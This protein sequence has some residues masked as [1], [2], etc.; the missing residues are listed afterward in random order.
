MT[1]YKGATRM[2]AD[3]RPDEKAAQWQ[4]VR[5]KTE[6][7]WRKVKADGT[8]DSMSGKDFRDYAFAVNDAINNGFHPRQDYW[9]IVTELG[10]THFRRGQMPAFVPHNDS[11]PLPS[12]DLLKPAAEAAGTKKSSSSKSGAEQ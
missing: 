12:L 9:L 10:T 5:Q 8:L 3:L 11:D 4:F 7:V 1:S 2:S 6:W